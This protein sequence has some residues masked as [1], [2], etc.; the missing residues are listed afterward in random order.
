MAAAACTR[1]TLGEA[2]DIVQWLN[3]LFE[4]FWRR[5]CDKVFPSAPMVANT[6]SRPL[7]SPQRHRACR[8]RGMLT[9]RTTRKVLG[10]AALN[11][12]KASTWRV[13][14]EA[15]QRRQQ[16]MRRKRPH[17]RRIVKPAVCRQAPMPQNT[18]SNIWVVQQDGVMGGQQLQTQNPQLTP[19]PVRK[20]AQEKW[21]CKFPI[22]GIGYVEPLVA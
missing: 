22:I 11:T 9:R 2:P 4:A 14:K 10:K 16:L 19:S 3:A 5:L 6:P 20:Q 17:Q 7:R 15:V 21:D 13:R 18:S 1:D 8:R 12:H